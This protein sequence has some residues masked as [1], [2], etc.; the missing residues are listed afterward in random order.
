MLRICL[1]RSIQKS[2]FYNFIHVWGRELVNA[3][4]IEEIVKFTPSRLLKSRNLGRNL[5]QH[6]NFHSQHALMRLRNILKICL[7]FWKSEAH[8]AYN[9]HTYVEKKHVFEC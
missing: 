9:H 2:K 4:Q 1:S 7:V 8:Y 5:G 3:Y 6:I